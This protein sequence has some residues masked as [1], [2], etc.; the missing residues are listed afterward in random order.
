MK[1]EAYKMKWPMI[2]TRYKELDRYDFIQYDFSVYGR[3]SDLVYDTVY[4]AYPADAV[5]YEEADKLTPTNKKWIEDLYALSQ[6]EGFEL[7][8]FL[9]P[10]VLSVEEQGQVNAVR[11]FAAENG[12]DFFDFNRFI[13]EIGINHYGDF[14][15]NYHLNGYGAEKLTRYIGEYLTANY[16][17]TDHRGDETYA[18]WEKDYTRFKQ[19][20]AIA[21]L[22]TAPSISIYISMLNQMEDVTW[23]VTFEG[24]YQK[25]TLE[26]DKVAKQLGLSEEQY[27]EGG[28]YACIDGK[29]RR[30]MDNS[31]SD[32]FVYEVNEYDSFKVENMS[33]T[34]GSKSNKSD[35]MFN[36]EPMGTV[37]DGIQ[38]VVYDHI[39]GEVVSTPGYF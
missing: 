27:Q 19:E 16:E 31:S 34:Q 37:E 21:G 36:V 25:S 15:D 9:A 10:T 23:F 38:F 29:L 1:N 33:L 11:D 6:E 17:L 22:K 30:I 24:D 32:V 2:H 20:K 8:F 39:T 3:G 14:F 5:A 18:L 4:A 35:I 28:T 12:L 26:L 7:V 13:S